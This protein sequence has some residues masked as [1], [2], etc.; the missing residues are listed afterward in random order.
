MKMFRLLLMV[1]ACV[2]NTMY[3]SSFVCSEDWLINEYS[4]IVATLERGTVNI[5]VHGLA[6]IKKL[7][8]DGRAIE[9][10]FSLNLNDHKDAY[11]VISCDRLTEGYFSVGSCNGTL[12]DYHLNCGPMLGMHIAPWMSTHPMKVTIEKQEQ[13]CCSI[14]FEGELEKSPIKFR[15][16]VDHDV[17]AACACL[18]PSKY[19]NHLKNAEYMSFADACALG[20]VTVISRNKSIDVHPNFE[21]ELEF[22]RIIDSMVKDGTIKIK[23]NSPWMIRLK[24]IGSSLFLNYLAI[25]NYIAKKWNYI[26]GNTSSAEQKTRIQHSRD[27]R[28]D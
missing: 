16:D 20:I 10:V 14:A 18:I 7:S 26:M 23:E 12:Y 19:T 28:R 1:T 3:A 17:T 24:T 13:G 4:L 9:P 15:I 11:N 8:E 25:K 21:A 2:G 27:L 6:D 22:D 5:G